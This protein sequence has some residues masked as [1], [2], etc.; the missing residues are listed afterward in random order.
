[1][2]CFLIVFLLT[3]LRLRVYVASRLRQGQFLPVCLVRVFLPLGVPSLFIPPRSVPSPLGRR[4][5]GR[6]RAPPVRDAERSDGRGVPRKRDERHRGARRDTLGEATVSSGAL[7]LS[8]ALALPAA[9][10]RKLSPQGDQ[11]G[12]ADV[13]RGPADDLRGLH[14]HP[15]RPHRHALRGTPST[16]VVA[17][18]S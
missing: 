12:P 7:H 16:S 15:Q 17:G 18:E 6:L 2:S 11:R 3:Y 14:I 10:C 13:L 4:S 1:V 8:F 5:I 9:A